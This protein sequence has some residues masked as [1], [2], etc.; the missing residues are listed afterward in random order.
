M[1]ALAM[2]LDALELTLMVSQYP[3]YGAASSA[4]NVTVLADVPFTF[5]IPPPETVMPSG[6]ALNFTGTPASMV[7][8]A[9][10]STVTLPWTILDDI[11]V[12]PQ[13]VLVVMSPET[14]VSAFT[15]DGRNMQGARRMTGV[16]TS[17]V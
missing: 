7:S 1:F 8:V 6:P 11:R 12:A 2:V 10:L 17:G 14:L 13:V 16:T 3:R 9:P 5:R 15:A 4:V